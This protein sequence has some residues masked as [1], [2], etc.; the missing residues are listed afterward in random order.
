M[1]KILVLATHTPERGDSYEPY[2]SLKRIIKASMMKIPAGVV[3]SS[4]SYHLS[5]PIAFR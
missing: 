3:D 2:L 5:L 4:I 1:S